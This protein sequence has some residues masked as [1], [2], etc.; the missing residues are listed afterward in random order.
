MVSAAGSGGLR[1]GYGAADITPPSGVDLTGFIAREGPCLGTRDPL[2]VRALVFEDAGGRRAALATCDLIGLGRHTVARV[3]RRVAGATG[4][5]EGAQLFA[6][7]HTHAGP[8][9]GVLTTI[10]APDPT[11][12]AALEARLGDALIAAAARLVPVRLSLGAADVPDGLA[13]NRVYRR[14]GQP[15][16]YDRQLIAVRVEPLA[17][18]VAF[19]CHAVALGAG[20]RHA[21]ADFV[22]PLR[23]DLEAAE[24]VPV[25][26]LNGC[27]GDVNPAG[28][29]DRGPATCEAL[30]RGLAGAARGA[31]A[32]AA[33]LPEPDAG[34]AGAA[35]AG[36]QEWVTLPFQPLRTPDEAA[37]LLAAGRERLAGLTPG[38]PAYRATQVTEMEYP[39][40]LLRL[41]YGSETLPEARAEVQALELGPLAVVALPGEVFSSLG[42][43]IKL[44]SPFPAPRTLVAGWSNDNVGYIP[45]ADAYPLGGYEVDLASRYYGQPAGWAREAGEALVAAAGRL[46]SRLGPPA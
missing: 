25:L 15:E 46:L 31:L 21:S 27:G 20:E 5:P 30:G 18:V 14:V 2:E 29:D 9:T 32:G 45:D 28:M 40:R 34:G 26:Y 16:R 4:I 33:P 44:G 42:R 8:E 13:L 19:A 10:G 1:A 43:A 12:L 23:R 22:A 11:Y 3:R 35:V 24:G 6:C 41:H 38:S 17:T 39:F 36:I 37:A 7:S